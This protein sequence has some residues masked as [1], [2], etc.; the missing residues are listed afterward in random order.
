MLTPR[1]RHDA[2]LPRHAVADTRC[3]IRLALATLPRTAL[4]AIRTRHVSADAGYRY[5]FGNTGIITDTPPPRC[6][7]AQ[8]GHARHAAPA[9]SCRCLHAARHA[10]AW[11]AMLR[12]RCRHASLCRQRFACCLLMS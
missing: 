3:Q 6:G 8:A 4:Y 1:L 12:R 9:L 2:L 7:A 10:A 11:R 5:E